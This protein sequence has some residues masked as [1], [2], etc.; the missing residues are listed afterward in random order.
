LGVMQGVHLPH[1]SLPGILM[2]S[3]TI[4]YIDAAEDALSF[5]ASMV[6][7]IGDY[8]IVI[9][10]NNFFWE[11]PIPDSVINSGKPMLISIS[12]WTREV[13]FYD[14][15]KEEF[16]IRTAFGGEENVGHIPLSEV[17]AIL[18]PDG[19]QLF[20]RSYDPYSFFGSDI[21]GDIEKSNRSGIDKSMEAILRNNPSL[22]KKDDS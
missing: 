14:D 15:S 20:T 7:D 21:K 8:G 10:P 11:N 13:S 16:Y 9:R 19:T 6:D 17:L 22:R 2:K 12:K 1:R 4:R 18:A 5:L 3:D